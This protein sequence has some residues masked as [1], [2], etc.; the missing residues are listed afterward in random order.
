[1]SG[2]AL[3][4]P[5]G[6]PVRL[7]FGQSLPGLTGRVTRVEPAA[8][9]K[10]SALGIEEQRVKTVLKLDSPQEEWRELGHGF[11]VVAHIVVWRK[12]DAL[13]V[14]LAA[15]FRRGGDWAA[16]RVVDGIAHIARVEIGERN[17]REAEILGGLAA[18]DRVILHPNDEIAD[19]TAVAERVITED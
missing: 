17:Q 15:L 11:R 14:P 3:R 16:F 18:G 9:T 1:L 19:G 7:S 8:F 10:V 5:I 2:D 6:A 12:D 4:V 13:V